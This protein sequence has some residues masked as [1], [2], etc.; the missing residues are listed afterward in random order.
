[1]DLSDDLRR[2][3]EDSVFN[4]LGPMP[5]VL[6]LRVLVGPE[7]VRDLPSGL[8]PYQHAQWVVRVA[9][10]HPD[11]D[12]FIGVVRNSD[13]AGQLLELQAIAA[14]LEADPGAWSAPVVAGLWVPKRWPFI[15]R[16]N[17]VAALSAMADGDGPPALAIE[18]SYGHGKK[19]MVEY[20]RCLAVEKGSFEPVIVELRKEPEPGVLESVVTELSMSLGEQPDIDTTHVEP[21]RQATILARDVAQIALTA[22]EPVW[23]VAHFVES[24]GLEAGVLVFVDELLSLVQGTAAVGAKLRIL[25]LCDELAV[26]E[27]KNAPPLDAR[28]ALSQVSDAEIRAWLEAAAP[29]KPPQVYDLFTASVMKQLAKANPALPRRLQWVSFNCAITQRRLLAVEDE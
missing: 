26:L 20:I 29:G 21:E 25:L 17:V 10:G 9:L 15:N 18:G 16:T 14:Q 13:A 11:P 19:T 2:Q 5:T 4:Y 12:V 28:H 1:M 22:T 3:L 8:S 24:T 6:G 27:L 7:A 23:F